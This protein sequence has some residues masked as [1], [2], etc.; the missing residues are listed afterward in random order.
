ME[1]KAKD[2]FRSLYVGILN[3]IKAADLFTIQL[4]SKRRHIPDVQE[5]ID[6]V[7][8]SPNISSFTKWGEMYRPEEFK[9]LE[10][11]GHFR[12]IGEQIILSTY[13]AL[14]I[15]LILKFKE[16][17]SYALQDND[18]DFIQNTFNKFSFRSLKEIKS[19]YFDIL[20][21]HLPSFDF[22][23]FTDEKSSFQAKDSWAALTLLANA[24]N[25]IVHRGS[26]TNYRIITPLDSWYPFEFAGMWVEHFDTNFD[27][28][29]YS[30]IKTSLYREYEQRLKQ[31]GKSEMS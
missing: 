14:E 31:A 5:L 1:P 26:S 29:F 21:I 7:L 23:Y 27:M 22:Q 25:E 9:L 4:L 15:Y 12:Q 6:T 18:P 10:E 28:F 2:V 3:I 16:Y 13:T 11:T 17:Y 30:K 20:K 24:R 19:C 8:T